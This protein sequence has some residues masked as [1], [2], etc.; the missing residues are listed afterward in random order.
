MHLVARLPS[1]VIAERA[2]EVF[3]APPVLLGR[4]KA[5]LCPDACQQHP[6]HAGE[7]PVGDTCPKPRQY[8]SVRAHVLLSPGYQV[9]MC[10]AFGLPGVARY[11]KLARHL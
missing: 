8:S 6:R 4:N 7:V 1:T 9:L 5:P 10:K 11:F 2:N 3:A